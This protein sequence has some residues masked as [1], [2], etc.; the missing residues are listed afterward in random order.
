MRRCKMRCE[1]RRY[2]L[3]R[4]EIELNSLAICALSVKKVREDFVVLWPS[5]LNRAYHFYVDVP[6]GQVGSFASMSRG[7]QKWALSTKVGAAHTWL[8]DIG[9]SHVLQYTEQGG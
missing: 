4:F 7:L 6:V 3:N 1:M 9:C 8:E 5:G 2:K